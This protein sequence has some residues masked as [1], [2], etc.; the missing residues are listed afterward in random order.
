MD[1]TAQ[2]YDL[3]CM[4]YLIYDFLTIYYICG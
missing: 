1:K 2:I 3:R 4:I